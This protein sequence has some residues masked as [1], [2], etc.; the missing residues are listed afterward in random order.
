MCQFLAMIFHREEA[1]PDC[2]REELPWEERLCGCS[3][4]TCPLSATKQTR[5]GGTRLHR[6]HGEPP[7]QCPQQQLLRASDMIF[8]DVWLLGRWVQHAVF[9]CHSWPQN[10]FFKCSLKT[11]RTQFRDCCSK[12]PVCLLGR[13]SVDGRLPRCCMRAG[14]GR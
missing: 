2:S 3:S 14:P 13:N 12:W 7:K 9:F 10:P 1:T 5:G 6:E 8:C 4:G 11:H